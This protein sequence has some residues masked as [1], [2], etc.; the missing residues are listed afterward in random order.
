MLML[1]SG[2]KNRKHMKILIIMTGFFPGQKFGGPPVS[3]DNFCTLMDNHDCYIVTRNHD[4]GDKTI[5]QSIIPGWNQRSN[6]KVLYL[7]DKE[8]CYKNYERV[9][10]EIKPDII[11]LQGLFQNCIIPCL[12]LAKKYN[13]A[14]LL[15]PRGELCAGALN[16]KKW[17]KVPYICVV[18]FLG[19]VRN[20]HWQSTSD[21]ETSA[22]KSVMNA[23]DGHV[24]ALENI[25]SIPKKEYIRREKKAGEASFVF[26][27]RIHPK[28]NLLSAIKYFHNIKGKAVFDIYGPIEDENYWKD[29][30][31][32]IEA[33]PDNV[34]VS[35]KGLVGHDQVHE[36]FSRYDAFLFPTLSENYGH[37]IAESL[38]VGTPVIISDQTPWNDVNETGAGWALPLDNE[39][40]FAN[41]IQKII[42]MNDDEI[43]KKAIKYLYQKMNL[44]SIR[45]RYQVC[46][47]FVKSDS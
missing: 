47:N 7:S 14:V 6:C 29:C 34:V 1:L 40:L 46:L 38:I 13:I 16:L 4:M 3:V 12:F 33:L 20:I 15:A 23:D 41:A 9:I 24:H 22:I 35:Y 11:Y 5:Y 39:Q 10:N 18:K 8:Y 2:E 31:A 27:S 42:D 30:Q 17:K 43:S 28:K 45:D 36:V 26:L 19:L 44:E 37:V 25:P 21:E 32:E